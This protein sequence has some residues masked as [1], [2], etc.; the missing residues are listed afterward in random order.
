MSEKAKRLGELAALVGGELS[1]DPDLAVSGVADFDNASTGQLAFVTDAR[2]LSRLGKCRASALI[3][4]AATGDLPLPAIRVRDPYL[5]V[6]RIHSLFVAAP[7]VAAGIHGQ[8]AV[9]RECLIPAE[10]SIGPFVSIGDRVHL[11]RR[12]ILHPGVV[13]YDDVQIGDDV[14]LHANVTVYDGC[15]IGDRVVI[16]AGAVIGADGFGYAADEKGCHVKRPQVGIVQIGADV[17]IGANAAIDRA[18][19]GRTLVRRGAKIDN[20]V[21]IGHN[22]VIGEDSLIVAQVGIAG[23]STIGRSV[24]LGGQV[25][26]GGHLH[27]GD[28][29]MVA[30]KSG[31][32]T[33]PEAGAVLA[34]IPAIA[35]QKWLRASAVYAR[36]PEMVKEL[37]ALRKKVAE[38]ERGEKTTEHGGQEEDAS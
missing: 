16:H 11:G 12:V 7:F 31:V 33:S 24:V 29:V 9:G 32:H 17:E 25:G 5:A 27:L 20:L 10:V 19:F 14:V 22:V 30:A 21:Q 35:H 2:R 1:G 13:L 36:L 28:R 8:A 3:V 23:S 34:G 15:L 6:A 4:P 26:L 38:L 18:T 37:R